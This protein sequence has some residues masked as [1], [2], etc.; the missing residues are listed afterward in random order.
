VHYCAECSYGVSFN[1]QWSFAMSLYAGCSYSV[2]Q[3][4]EWSYAVSLNTA[5]RYAVSVILSLI[6]L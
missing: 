1:A 2:L 5:C 6:M 3:Y 4:T